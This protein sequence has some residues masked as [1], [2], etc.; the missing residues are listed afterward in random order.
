MDINF[1]NGARNGVEGNYF[2]FLGIGVGK[3]E[4]K[5]LLGSVNAE[6]GAQFPPAETSAEQDVINKEV[7]RQLNELKVNRDKAK[8]KKTRSTLSARVTA[9]ETFLSDMKK[10]RNELYAYEKKEEERIAEEERQRLA[11]E[12]EAAEQERQRLAREKEAAD[13][14]E[15]AD[16]EAAKLVEL[17]KTTETEAAVPSVKEAVKEDGIIGSIKKGLSAITG[18]GAAQPSSEGQTGQPAKKS[19]TLLYVGIAAAVVVGFLILRKKK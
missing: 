18:G 19:K 4:A 16:K 3:S 7:E 6:L 11:R 12:K 13:A 14:K 10:Y 15:A 8:S 1:Q 5:K 9:Y 17:K 2:Q